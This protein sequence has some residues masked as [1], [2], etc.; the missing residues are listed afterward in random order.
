MPILQLNAYYSN[1]VQEST[2]KNN[3]PKQKNP[4]AI[5]TNIYKVNENTNGCRTDT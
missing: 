3:Q 2:K 4:P 5:H 1:S